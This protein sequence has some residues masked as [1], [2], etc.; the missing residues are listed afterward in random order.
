[1]ARIKSDRCLPES[2]TTT[3]EL[4]SEV[5]RRLKAGHGPQAPLQQATCTEDDEKVFA[6]ALM[7]HFHRGRT[8]Q[9][10]NSVR[11]QAQALD[12]CNAVF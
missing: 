11:A 3:E 7:D 12:L 8:R 1:M 5:M 10:A 4:S 6:A 9:L 2:L